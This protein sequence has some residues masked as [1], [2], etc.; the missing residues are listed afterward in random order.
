MVGRIL[1]AVALVAGVSGVEA[2]SASANAHGIRQA[3]HC[4]GCG[5]Y[6]G[7][8]ASETWATPFSGLGSPN[9]IVESVSVTSGDSGGQM[10]AGVL[11]SNNFPASDCLSDT[12]QKLH[13]FAEGL[14]AG[15]APFCVTASGALPN[16]A[17]AKF[18]AQRGMSCGTCWVGWED[19]AELFVHDLSWDGDATSFINAGGEVVFPG[20]LNPPTVVNV[21]F[22]ETTAWA[23]TSQV[24]DDPNTVWTTVTG[25]YTCDYVDPSP[26]G[27]NNATNWSIGSLPDPFRVKWTG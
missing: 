21:D 16:A 18:V 12:S 20:N 9:G 5:F 15:G 10:Q 22:G 11:Q 8:R 3:L 6:R 2:G 17:T 23:R 13:A 14:T 26:P 7:T 4:S 19:S 25:G 1:F 27:C 24:H